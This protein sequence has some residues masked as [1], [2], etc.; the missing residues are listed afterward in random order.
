VKRHGDI[1]D[2]FA[3]DDDDDVIMNDEDQEPSLPDANQIKQNDENCRQS[4][5]RI[6]RPFGAGQSE[7]IDDVSSQCVRRK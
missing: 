7:L 3:E 5:R 1:D 2:D 6:S 4:R